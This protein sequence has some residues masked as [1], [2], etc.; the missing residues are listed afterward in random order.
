VKEGELSGNTDDRALALPS[1]NAV[2][3]EITM[4]AFETYIRDLQEIRATGAA[5]KE[6]SYYGALEKLLNELGKTLKPKVRCV[7]QLKNIGG[8]GMPDGGLFTAS[9]FQ[10][11]TG[12]TPAN[13]TNP[14]RGVIEIKGT[15]DNAWVT[16]Q[17]QQVSKY[18]NKYRQ[19]L[20]TNYRDFVLIGQDASG[21]PATLETYRLAKNEA[22]FWQKAKNPK[23]FAE[24]QEEQVTEYLKR[25]ML[26]SASIA[27]PQDLA[28][29]L[30]SYAKDAKARVEKTDL[31]A[32]ETLKKA[33]EEALGIAFTGDKKDP[34]KGERF[35]KSTLIQTL[36]Y[37]I[38]SAWVLWHKQQEQGRFDWRVAGY[39][40]HVPMI[41]AL[42]EKVATATHVRKLDLEEVLNWTGEA[43]NRVDRTS[44]FSKFDEGQAV[45]YFYEP[46]LEAFDPTLRKELGVWYTPPE[47]VQ[48]MVARVDTVL[49]EELQIE[50]GLADP[51]VYILDPCCGT[52]AFLVEVL[53][54]IEANLQDKGMGALVGSQLKEA[55]MKRVFGFEI[56]TAPFVVAH[57]QLGLLLQNLGVPLSD[58]EER[59][60]VYLTNALTGWNPLDPEK[61]KFVQLQLA[62][63][64]ELQEERDAAEKIKQSKKVL[65]V[66]GNPP[67]N[68][69]AGMAIGEERDLSNAY[70][71]TKKAP[72]SQGQGLNELYVRF[73]RMAERQ[74][75][76]ETGQGVVCFI[77]N[78]SWLDGLSHPGM[79]ERYLEVFDDIWIDCLN[80]D[81]FATGKLTPDGKPDPSIFSTEWNKEGIKTGTAIALL[82]RKENHQQTD[83]VKFRDIWGTTKWQQLVESQDQS[84]DK[85]CLAIFTELWL[86]WLEEIKNNLPIRSVKVRFWLASFIYY[87]IQQSKY[88]IFQP[89]LFLGLP[90]KH[91][92]FSANYPDYPLLPE[93]FPAFFPGVQTKRDE[94]VVDIDKADLQNRI[95]QYFDASINDEEMKRICPRSMETTNRFDAKESREYL[96]RRGLLSEYIV[97][98]CHRPFDIRWIYWEPETKLL[99]EKVSAYFPQVFKGN[100][101][102]TSQQKPR[103][104]WSK[105]QFIRN[106][107]CLDLMDRGA[108]CIPLFIKLEEGKLD[109]FLNDDR[110][111]ENG[112]NLNLS[113]KAIEYLKEVGTIAD[114]EYLFYHVLAILHAPNYASENDGALRQ[115]WARIPLPDNRETLIASAT[116]GRQIAALLDPETPVSGVTSGKLRPELKTIAVVSRIGTGNLDPNTDFALTAGWG[117]A[118]QNNV[119]MPG[120]GKVSDRPYTPEE[121]IALTPNPSPKAGE[122]LLGAATRD[123]YLNDIAYWKNIPDR[124]WSYTIGGYQVIKKWL[125]YREQELL[126]RSLKQEEVIEVTQM[127]RRITAILLLEPELDANYQ[128]VKQSTYPW[129]AQK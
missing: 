72:K 27:S 96:L 12:D 78:Y 61:E 16:A 73:F 11:K 30:A 90:F 124:V 88:H 2:S 76:E 108:S 79:R 104:D 22:E 4:S 28:W 47:I 102:M 114:A 26:Q 86:K 33:L 92:K 25:V 113:D 100:I 109:L 50:D 15:G 17:T 18:W 87:L 45:Q 80:G 36:F 13:P 89:A 29:F 77:S 123:I 60:G 31:P 44:F 67:Y 115:D 126:G 117:H 51:N 57:L 34:K 37:G 81:K 32:L 82:L 116:L 64:P 7:M 1:L 14:E 121:Q 105:P 83:A 101:W 74:I 49:R 110:K 119:T 40:L 3:V 128:A 91:L 43:L 38:F 122:G 98:F 5:V 35:F 107:G 48:Y 20:V 54:R 19:V 6:T 94:L 99:G 75:V 56:L 62:A 106:L 118:G 65:V 39:Y 59:V 84:N 71:T 85:L 55:A 129:S 68:G 10:K 41:K 69:F 46:F 23:Q 21:Q 97:R 52:G 112:L 93:L 66:L 8:A 24:E 9:Q 125:S 63:L 103:R 42:F 95:G 120:R 58:E 111:L 70:R 127:A 53:K